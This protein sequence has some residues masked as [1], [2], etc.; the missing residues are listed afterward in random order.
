MSQ[1]RAGD[2][3]RAL[4]QALA[5][6][7]RDASPRAWNAVLFETGVCL[8]DGPAPLA[9]AVAFAQGRLEEARAQELR[10]VEADMLHVLGAALGRAGDFDAGRSALQ[11]SGRIS[12]ELGL[13]YM[14]QWSKRNLG[15]LELAAGDPE[16]AEKVLRESWDVLVEMGLHS[17]LGETAVPLAEALHAQGR[18]QDAAETLKPVKD[19]W[20]SGDASIAAPRLCMRARLQ[21]VDGFSAIALQ[22]AERALRLVRNTDLR[23]LQADT[24]LTHAQM[25]R[26]AG[27][28]DAALGSALEA[29]RISE[30]KG[31]AVGVA[32]AQAETIQIGAPV[33]EGRPGA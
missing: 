29:Q 26:L 15:H 7:S 5:H 16:A 27:D 11:E 31:Y 2:G 12:D 14:E 24:L 17:S 1:G 32:R 6:V 13:R 18:D 21:A 19:E 25:A 28:Y 30:R 3:Q 20:A 8:I 4:E 33:R 22:T 10:G 23:C 9:E